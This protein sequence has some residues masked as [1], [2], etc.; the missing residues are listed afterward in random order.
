M[1]S[2]DGTVASRRKEFME[3]TGAKGN[4]YFHATSPDN[5]NRI[6]AEGFNLDQESNGRSAGEGV[7]LHKDPREVAQYGEQIVGVKLA[8]GTRIA[9]KVDTT[10]ATMTAIRQ[11]KPGQDHGEAMLDHLH[12]WDYHGHTD[13][14]DGSA[15]VHDPSRVKPVMNAPAP[16]Q[17]REHWRN[18][19]VI[20]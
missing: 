16:R 8:P 6:M 19:G 11:R 18:Q 5:A 14:D 17:W 20:Q 9:G 10:D 4:L 13:V 15:I 7:Y 3:A 1:V 2:D 12:S